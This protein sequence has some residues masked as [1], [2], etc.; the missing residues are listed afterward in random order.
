MS[1]GE[2]GVMGVG[3]AFVFAVV[4]FLVRAGRRRIVGA[5]LGGLAAGAF[6]S[7]AMLAG[8]A[9][10]LWSIPGSF[11]IG[12]AVLLYGIVSI[13]CAPIPLISW[14]TARRFGW[15]GLVVLVALAAIVGPIRDYRVAAAFP[16][17]IEFRGGVLAVLAVALSYAG[18][19]AV[20]HIVMSCSR[21]VCWRQARS[22][23]TSRITTGCTELARIDAA[24]FL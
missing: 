24:P 18:L 22:V 5:L 2:L 9:T 10:G 11:E 21:N 7:I 1:E 16:D 8:E 15:K 23:Q 3:Y 12:F 13:S 4:A 6:A 17:W 19:V 14:R 20:G